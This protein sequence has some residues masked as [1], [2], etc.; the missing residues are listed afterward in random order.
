MIFVR[1]D[2]K[3]K[4]KMKLIFLR[5]AENMKLKM[6]LIFVRR[7]EICLGRAESESE[8]DSVL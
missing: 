8:L 6:E 2:D 1:R 3:M 7:D 4:L 5:R